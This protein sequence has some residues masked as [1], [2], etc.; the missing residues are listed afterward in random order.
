MYLYHESGVPTPPMYFIDSQLPLLS[1]CSLP[2][3]AWTGGQRV[4]EQQSP[5]DQC[6]NSRIQNRG[7]ISTLQCAKK[8]V[9]FLSTSVSNSQQQ[10][11]QTWTFTCRVVTIWILASNQSPISHLGRV[12]VCMTSDY[13]ACTPSWSLSLAEKSRM[14][15]YHWTASHPKK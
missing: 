4:C 3:M 7:I 11:R 10:L 14:I 15:I 12:V 9:P 5:C 6:M 2:V 13:M 8:K 1:P